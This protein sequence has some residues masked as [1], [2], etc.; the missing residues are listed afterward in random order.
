[1]MNTLSL[2][3]RLR[4]RPWIGA[5]TAA[6]CIALLL[7][8]EGTGARD[9]SDVSGDAR[10]P[11][12][13]TTALFQ[14]DSLAYRL[15]YRDGR[16]EGTAMVTFRN[17]TADTVFFIHCNGATGTALQREVNGDWVDVWHSV[18]NGC[19]SAPITVAPGDSLRRSVF[20]F[21]GYQPDTAAAVSPGSGSAVHRLV[22]TAAVKDF[23]PGV[24]Y[25]T[26]LPLEQRASNP[27]LLT[28]APR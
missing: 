6:G 19:F 7:A 4:S 21:D 1:M 28:G 10:E 2:R 5:I 8:C 18:Q 20:L 26:P 13:D 27:F 25:G 9:T 11:R 24:S 16:Y 3:K 17:R 23:A 22:W 14:T 12:R 15:T